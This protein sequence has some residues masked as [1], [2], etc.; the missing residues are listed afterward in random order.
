MRGRVYSLT[1]SVFLICLWAVYGMGQPARSYPPFTSVSQFIEYD[2][3]GEVVNVSTYTRYESSTGDWRVVGKSALD[4][5]ATIYRRGK[6]IYKSSLRTSRIIKETGHAPGCSLRTADEL[7][8]D[9]KFARTEEILGFKAYVLS[10]RPAKDL[11]IENYFV[12]ELGGGTPFKQ[13]TTYTHGP[14]YVSEPISVTLGEPDASDVSGPDFLTV[15]QEAT[16]LKNIGDHLRV[17]READYPMEALN[18]RVSGVVRVA[19]T[20]DENGTVIMASPMADAPRILRDAAVEAAYKASFKP[21]LV[22]GRV[23]IGKGVIDYQFVLSK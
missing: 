12:P 15:E 16:F 2:S 10:D 18:R 22:A 13:V 21:I 19:V 9:P 3:K 17:K 11:L 20:V 4:E 7:S 1:A 14:K 8:R 5:R 6:G 23:V